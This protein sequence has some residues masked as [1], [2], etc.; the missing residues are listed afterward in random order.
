MEI[1]AS[2]CSCGVCVNV[3]PQ[4]AVELKNHLA[5]IDEVKCV[6][7]ICRRWPCGLCAKACPVGAI[8]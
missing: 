6:E 8:R 2:C 1:K 7:F 3:C 4:G 5:E